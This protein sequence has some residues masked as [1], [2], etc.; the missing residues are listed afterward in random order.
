MLIKYTMVNAASGSAGG[1]TAAKNRG[2]NYWRARVVPLNP[3]SPAQTEVRLNLAAAATAWRAITSAQRTD[4]NSYAETLSGNNR[5]GDSSKPSGINAF[6]GTNSLRHLASLA[7]LSPAPTSGGKGTF[8]PPASTPVYDISSETL[9][10]D[11]TLTDSWAATAGGVLFAF[12]SRPQSAGVNYFK[13][14]YVLGDF[15]VR[16]GS[17]P[18]DPWVIDAN[19]LPYAYTAGQRVFMR[20]HAMDVLGRISTPWRGTFTVQA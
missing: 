10:V 15:L 4:W 2:G 9:T 6:C 13:G 14:P 5:V 8:T 3:E 20:L 16:G 18:S 1:L 12:V 19:V 17:A 11:I 7:Q